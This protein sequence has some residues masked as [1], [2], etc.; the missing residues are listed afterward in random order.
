MRRWHIAVLKWCDLCKAWNESDDRPVGRRFILFVVVFFFRRTS[1]VRAGIISSTIY[2]H[3]THALWWQCSCIY[4]SRDVLWWNEVTVGRTET[5]WSSVETRWS[6]VETRW[7][8]ISTT[9][10]IDLTD[11]G[12]PTDVIPINHF[13]VFHYVYFS[14]I[15][16]NIYGLYVSLSTIHTYHLPHQDPVCMYPRLAS[17]NIRRVKKYS[18]GSN[19]TRRGG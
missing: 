7:G 18:R 16:H 1:V 3:T 13:N 8:S 6:S 2:R 17:I 12:T 4:Q 9:S 15:S 5:R 11:S 19:T 10:K 14:Q